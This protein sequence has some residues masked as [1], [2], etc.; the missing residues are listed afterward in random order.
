MQMIFL[1]KETESGESPTL[2]ATEDS[3]VIQGYTVNDAAL[4]ATLDIAAGETVVE[5]YAR[6]FAH[7]AHDGV[8][9]TVTNWLPPIVHVKENGNYL[10]QGVRLADETARNRMALPDNEDAI[11]VPKAAIHALLEEAACA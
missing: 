8:S 4:L 3:Y 11:V 5:V 2:Y 7:L 9:G 6:L 1:G 10:I